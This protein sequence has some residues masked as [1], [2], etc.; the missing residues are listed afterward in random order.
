LEDGL[1]ETQAKLQQHYPNA[2]AWEKLH[3]TNR[4]LQVSVTNSIKKQP[5]HSSI[6]ILVAVPGELLKLAQHYSFL[7][8]EVLHFG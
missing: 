1:T 5:T 7:E 2:K 3:A 8:D 4:H 6:I